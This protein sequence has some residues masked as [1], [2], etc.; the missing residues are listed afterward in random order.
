M[1]AERSD[2]LNGKG[3]VR[4]YSY[5]AFFSAALFFSGIMSTAFDGALKFLDFNTVLGSFGRIGTF[6]ESGASLSSDYRGSGGT[7]VKEGFLMAVSTFPT[8]MFALGVVSVVDRY[9]GLRAAQRLLTTLLAMITGFQSSDAGAGM[10]RE[11]YERGQISEAERDIFAAFQFTSC[12]MLTNYFV[13]SAVF[14]P[15]LKDMGIIPLVSLALLFFQKLAAANLVR[16]WLR[17]EKRNGKGGGE[18]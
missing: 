18:K 4:W 16:L 7:G 1:D 5:L 15:V 14:L 12:G 10:T 3:P 8:V 2:T 17:R 11:L 13:C 6:T 9:D